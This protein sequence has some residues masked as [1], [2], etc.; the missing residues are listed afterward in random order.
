[1]SRRLAGKP[2]TEFDPEAAPSTNQIE[3]FLSLRSRIK[4]EGAEMQEME[5]R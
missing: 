5:E 1:M 3:V 2:V 4:Q